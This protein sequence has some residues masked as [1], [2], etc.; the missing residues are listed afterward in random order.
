MKTARF[1]LFIPVCL[2]LFFGCELFFPPAS[3]P[4]YTL[5]YG[6]NGATGGSAPIDTAKYA[7][8]A[9]ASVLDN[10]GALVKTGYLFV[11]W[12]SRGD[13]SGV[14]YPASATFAMGSADLT[15]YAAWTKDPTYAHKALSAFSILSPAALGLID[16]TAKA[17]AVTLPYGTSVPALVAFFT[18]TGAHGLLR[19]LQ[20]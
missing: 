19:R 17:I 3:S 8:G 16:E 6:T 2:G 7:P 1:T 4:T 18:T 9:M 5:T 14:S 10:S 20:L 11:G 12:N 13:G 15:L